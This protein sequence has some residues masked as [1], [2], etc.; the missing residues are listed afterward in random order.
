MSQKSTVTAMLDTRSSDLACLNSALD[1][2]QT[3]EILDGSGDSVIGAI[4]V[5]RKQESFKTCTSL[6]S[7][8][9]VNSDDSI[10]RKIPP[11]KRKLGSDEFVTPANVCKLSSSLCALAI[12][13]KLKQ[14][15]PTSFSS[16]SSMST[17]DSFQALPRVDVQPVA[18][19]PADTAAP[20]QD[21]L[22]L[23]TIAP[24]AA[25]HGEAVQG[26]S[27]ATPQAPAR[28]IAP[29]LREAIQVR[30]NVLATPEYILPSPLY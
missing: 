2:H 18:P 21:P 20:D 1:D 8:S 25:D 7:M 16:S 5:Y 19:S 22:E 17:D 27:Q 23:P 12:M 26:P 13:E 9:S 10:N 6:S 4:P 24:T 29:S 14:L 3:K 28:R 11:M 30:L 15:Q